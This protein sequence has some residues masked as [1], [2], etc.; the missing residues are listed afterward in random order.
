MLL[1]FGLEQVDTDANR[2][3]IMGRAMQDLMG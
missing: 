1:G 2:A 3:T